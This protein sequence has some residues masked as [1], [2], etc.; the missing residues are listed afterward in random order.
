MACYYLDLYQ[1]FLCLAGRCPSTCCAGWKIVVDETAKDWF[2]RLDNDTLRRDILEHIR[3]RDGE[4]V[5]VNQPD[6]RCSMLDRDGLCRIQK[7]LGEKA[8]CHTCRKFPRLTSRVDG[9]IWMS[10]AASCPVVAEYLWKKTP[11]WIKQEEDGNCCEADCRAFLPVRTG[12]LRYRGHCQ[13]IR[14]QRQMAGM[15]SE[16]E[17]VISAAR[18]NWYRFGLF[19]DLADRCLEL[20]KE[21]P[22]QP[23]LAGSFDYYGQEEKAVSEVLWDMELFASRWQEQFLVFADNYLS[24]RLFSRFLESQGEQDGRRYCQVTGELSLIYV[25]LFSRYHSME[26]MGETDI[27]ET[28]NWVYRF[29]AH[30]MVLSEKV[31]GMFC[32]V[33]EKPEDSVL[34]F[35]C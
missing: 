13:E 23:Y 33:F 20:L 14:N 7:Q 29:C 32:D 27:L 5:F 9:D 3:H 10:M 30:G 19:L 12:L 34:L 24:Y 8:L 4:D 2:G 31:T 16:K 18:E 1:D 6:G 17:Q 28:I 35:L 25:I 22:G 26:G 15:V 11:R 21:F